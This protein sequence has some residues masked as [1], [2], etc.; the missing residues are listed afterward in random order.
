MVRG[1]L[2]D[3]L[4]PVRDALHYYT[5]LCAASVIS[6]DGLN[7][8]QQFDDFQQFNITLSWTEFQNFPDYLYEAF[9]AIRNELNLYKYANSR[10]Q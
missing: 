4:L 5:H 3:P 2:K 6:L 8:L 9:N 1:A 10:N 7:L